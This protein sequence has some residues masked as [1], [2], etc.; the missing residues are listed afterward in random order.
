ML[1]KTVFR[2]VLLFGAQINK[3]PFME[4]VRGTYGSLG[5]PRLMCT[6]DIRL[7]FRQVAKECLGLRLVI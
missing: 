4:S 5:T 3:H 1:N 7:S 6:T 2:L